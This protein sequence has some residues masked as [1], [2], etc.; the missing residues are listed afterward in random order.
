MEASY[1]FI[2]MID[3]SEAPSCPLI[4]S[5][6]M[7]TCVRAHL[8]HKEKTLRVLTGE[9][10]KENVYISMLNQPGMIRLCITHVS[11]H[12]PQDHGFGPD[13]FL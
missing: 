4:Y 3:S 10:S 12:S 1:L 13:L 11:R 2:L 5:S 7:R 8:D 6:R 9:G